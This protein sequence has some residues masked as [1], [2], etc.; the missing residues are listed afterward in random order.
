MIP[1]F[2]LKGF[3]F[4]L[5][6]WFE[7]NQRDLPWRKTRDAYKIWISEIMLQ[8]TRVE[9]VKNYYLNWMKNWPSIQDLARAKEVDVLNC[10]KGLGYYSRA[11]NILK[12]AVLIVEKFDGYLPEQVEDLQ[13]LPGIGQYTAGA[14]ASLAYGKIEPIVDGNV[15][16]VYARIFERKEPVNQTKSQKLFYEIARAQLPNKKISEFNQGLMELGALVCLP[17]NPRCDICPV[18][19]FCKSYQNQSQKKYPIRVKK[20]EIESVFRV[21]FFIVKKKRV[22]LVQRHKKGLY[23]GMWELPSFVVEADVIELQKWQETLQ[24]ELEIKGKIG[25]KLGEFKHTFTRFREII[26]VYS[27][28][29]FKEDIQLPSPFFSAR[30]IKG[31]P[32]GSVQTRIL[33]ELFLR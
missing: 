7:K 11:K 25:R 32:M 1:N 28:A 21:A 12:T 18:Q 16:R 13:K 17:Q 20:R 23:Q 9:A 4:C 22:F 15:A 8:Q 10:W 14:I 19:K 33:K 2:L 29:L 24:I 3:S 6:N 30:E 27:F 31:L 26:F 5:I